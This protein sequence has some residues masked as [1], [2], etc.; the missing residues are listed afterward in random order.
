MTYKANGTFRSGEITK[1]EFVGIIKEVCEQ[2]KEC[3]KCVKKKLEIS[4][5]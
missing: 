5:N 4:L 1:E 2:L 3:I